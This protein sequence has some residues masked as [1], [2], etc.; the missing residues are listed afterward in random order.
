MKKKKRKTAKCQSVPEEASSYFTCPTLSWKNCPWTHSW[1]CLYFHSH[2]NNP[3]GEASMRWDFSFLMLKNIFKMAHDGKVTAHCTVDVFLFLFISLAV[4]KS[5]LRVGAGNEQCRFRAA[6]TSSLC[7]FTVCV[8]VCLHPAGSDH[9]KY[10]HLRD[11]Q[12]GQKAHFL[13]Q[14]R[15]GSMRMLFTKTQ[16]YT[17]W[18]FILYN[19]LCCLVAGRGIDFLY[20]HF[21]HLLCK[22]CFL[23]SWTL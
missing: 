17:C 14:H 4:T 13:K 8:S 16:C 7:H 3:L 23:Y 10:W 19:T 18:S 15:F 2:R 20:A 22:K 12:T 1:S 21:S 11:H 9:P 6:F 5:H